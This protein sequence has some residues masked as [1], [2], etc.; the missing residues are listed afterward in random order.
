MQTQ[1]NR[2]VFLEL[3]QLIKGE[4]GELET[5]ATSTSPRASAPLLAAIIETSHA[6]QPTA[7]ASSLCQ[8]AGEGQNRR[9]QTDVTRA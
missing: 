8:V 1:D 9:E 7:R 2:S 6:P 5:P 4:G 3:S